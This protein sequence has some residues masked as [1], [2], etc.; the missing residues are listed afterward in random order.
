M[1]WM[2]S[3]SQASQ[4]VTRRSILECSRT[5]GPPR[6]TFGRALN[7]SI[8]MRTSRSCMKT[9]CVGQSTRITIPNLWTR[10]VNVDLSLRCQDTHTSFGIR[11]KERWQTENVLT[12]TLLYLWWK[13]VVGVDS[14]STMN[15]S[16]KV[17]SRI[18]W[19]KRHLVREEGVTAALSKVRLAPT[20]PQGVAI[21]M[22]PMQPQWPRGSLVNLWWLWVAGKDMW[23]GAN[24]MRVIL[25]T[26]IFVC[27][28]GS[29]DSGCL[30]GWLNT[31]E[32]YMPVSNQ[33]MS[34]LL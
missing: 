16:H 34:L 30:I 17:S 7:F 4:R 20:M 15:F 11:T 3:V 31:K 6:L 28:S 8:L 10:D 21:A 2:S 5:N 27:C 1:E 13:I 19:S 29:A 24:Q 18:I 14:K 32:T 12:N 26:R 9:S 23:T 33:V 22:L 25:A